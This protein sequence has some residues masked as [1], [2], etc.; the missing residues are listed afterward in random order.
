LIKKIKNLNNQV[1]PLKVDE[2]FNNNPNAIIL[3]PQDKTI[4]YYETNDYILVEELY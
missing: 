1:L 4:E 2:I 3:I